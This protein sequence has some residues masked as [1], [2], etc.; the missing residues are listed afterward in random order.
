MT[1][2]PPNKSPTPEDAS[3]QSAASNT[4]Q[5]E[6]DSSQFASYQEESESKQEESEVND[7]VQ[8]AEESR[9]QCR[10]EESR[11]SESVAVDETSVQSSLAF[12][13]NSEHNSMLNE[14]EEEKQESVIDQNSSS[15]SKVCNLL[16]FCLGHGDGISHSRCVQCA[17]LLQVCVELKRL[18]TN[19]FLQFSRNLNQT[20]AGVNVKLI[21]LMLLLDRR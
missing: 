18:V 14:R 8:V 6:E 5:Q 4:S 19:F 13:S 3:A 17:C 10:D 12:D 21:Q 7:V 20:M 9:E 2:P 1:D 16:D 11:G 15:A